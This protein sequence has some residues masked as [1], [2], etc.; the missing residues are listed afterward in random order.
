L[1]KEAKIKPVPIAQPVKGRKVILKAITLAAFTNNIYKKI[2][3]KK[4]G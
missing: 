1:S 3:N 4:A 2:L